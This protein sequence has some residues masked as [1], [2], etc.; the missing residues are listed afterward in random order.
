[1]TDGGRV[2]AD[3]SRRPV[4]RLPDVSIVIP[5][6][7]R[8]QSLKRVLD[9]L[10]A[11]TVAPGRFEVIVVCDG[12]TDGTAEMCRGLSPE[13]SLR[14]IEQPQQG[15]AGA[16]NRGLAEAVGDLIVFLDDDVVPGEELIARHVQAHV[17]HER[18]VVIGPLLAPPGFALAPWT[19]WEANM[20]ADQYRSM[21]AGRWEP[22]PR[23]FYT[24]NASVRREHLLAAGGFD[25]DFHRAEDVELAYRLQRLPLTFHFSAGAQGWHY[26]QRSLRSWLAAARAYGE[27][28]V[29]MYRRGRLMTLQSMSAEFK[30]RRR[31]LRRLA[32]ACVGRPALLTP[33]VGVALA[34]ARVAAWLQLTGLAESAYSAVFNL[35][36]WDAIS[37][38][39]GGRS[40]FWR[41]VATGKAD[42]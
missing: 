31:S 17:D 12:C 9:A 6:H 30:W 16:R 28:D 26:A 36:Y 33:T 19:R 7:Q 39:L 5:T 15:P 8:R 27:A 21:T 23:Q 10:G 13:Y 18:A 41:L 25:P 1:M 20:L 11:Q 14:V 4:T 38:Q 22:S 3:A 37:G 24:G 34:V 32:R 2:D 35:T 40:A 29:A 42:L